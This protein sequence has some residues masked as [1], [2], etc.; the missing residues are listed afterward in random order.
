MSEQETVSEVEQ[1]SEVTTEQVESD[2]T[3]AENL[4]GVNDRLL[5]ESKGYKASSQK[6]KNE[7]AELK[8]RLERLEAEKVEKDGNLEE[9]VKFYKGK[10]DELTEA[11]TSERVEKIDRDLKGSLSEVASD[12]Q[13]INLLLNNPD[14]SDD[15]KAAVDFNTGEVDQEILKSVYEKDKAKNPFLY[16]VKKLAT[17]VTGKPGPTEKVQKPLSKMNEDERKK[18]RNEKLKERYA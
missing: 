4:E 12:C 2:L 11:L 18:L 9:K 17:E 15:F 1:T 7:N 8:K 13:N 16:Q 3:D 14:Y 5:K 6:Y 10:V